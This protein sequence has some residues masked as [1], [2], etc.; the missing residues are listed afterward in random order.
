MTVIRKDYKIIVYDL[1]EC[2]V[3][4]I[5]NSHPNNDFIHYYNGYLLFLHSVDETKY[6]NMLVDM[7]EKHIEEVYYA[8]FDKI[9]P[10]KTP[11]GHELF[12]SERPEMDTMFREIVDMIKHEHQS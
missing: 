6:S 9:V 3:Q 7:G 4:E 11:A 12:I 5:L 1:I 8:K 2:T 10:L